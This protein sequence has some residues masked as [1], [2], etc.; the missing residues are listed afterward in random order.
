[1]VPARSVVFRVWTR[2]A[3]SQTRHVSFRPVSNLKERWLLVKLPSRTQLR[4]FCCAGCS[5]RLQPAR[6]YIPPPIHGTVGL[7]CRSVSLSQ[8]DSAQVVFLLFILVSVGH[9]FDL[10]NTPELVVLRRP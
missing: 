7:C 10:S 6:S 9:R 5:T 2:N 3:V 1:M 8:C 4:G